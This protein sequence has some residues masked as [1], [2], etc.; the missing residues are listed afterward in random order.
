MYYSD[1]STWDGPWVELFFLFVLPDLKL[2]IYMRAE[3]AVGGGSK[4]G[5][6]AGAVE[7]RVQRKKV[8]WAHNN[9][10]EFC[11]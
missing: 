1:R 5:S 10:H 7:E 6:D 8:A 11:L 9:S 2:E 3:L 4:G